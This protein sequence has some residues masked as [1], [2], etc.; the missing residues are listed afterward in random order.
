MTLNVSFDKTISSLAK[1]AKASHKLLSITVKLTRACPF[2]SNDGASYQING[3]IAPLKGGRKEQFKT[4][5][6]DRF[7][8]SYSLAHDKN[9]FTP[10]LSFQNIFKR[11]NILYTFL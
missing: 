9:I 2:T 3:K 8:P 4:F 11:Q 10:A 5:R 1:I 6:V 7:A